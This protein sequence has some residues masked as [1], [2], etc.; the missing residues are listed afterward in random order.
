MC[1]AG[2]IAKYLTTRI[3]QAPAH[4]SEQMLAVNPVVAG[5]TLQLKTSVLPG[6]VLR[7][8]LGNILLNP[9]NTNGGRFYNPHYTN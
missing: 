9:Q 5:L 1:Q 8:L 6:T 3:A 2:V 4:I 7:D